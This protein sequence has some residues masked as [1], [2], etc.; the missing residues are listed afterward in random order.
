[1]Y[2]FS[3]WKRKGALKLDKFCWMMFV[4]PP[5]HDINDLCIQVVLV[6]DDKSELPLSEMLWIARKCLLLSA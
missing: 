3:D 5:F 4:A 1:M 2:S 6:N